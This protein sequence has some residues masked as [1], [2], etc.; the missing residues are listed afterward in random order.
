[1]KKFLLFLQSCRSFWFFSEK[2][3]F[4]QLFFPLL[5][6]QAVFMRYVVRL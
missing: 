6:L 2:T 4:I 1:V 5:M 3:F